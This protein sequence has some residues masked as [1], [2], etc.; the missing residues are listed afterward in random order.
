MLDFYQKRKLRGILLF[1]A[2][3]LVIILAGLL[4]AYSAFTR[5]Q[6]AVEM[7]DRRE[8]AE[9]SVEEL[10]LRK[11]Q[12]EAQVRYLEDERGIEAELRRQFDVALPGEEVVVITEENSTSTEQTIEPLPSRR[13]WYQFWE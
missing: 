1:P 2:T 11:R 7:A 6:V 8:A 10:E 13:P 4:L 9:V 3:R 12:L 5:Y